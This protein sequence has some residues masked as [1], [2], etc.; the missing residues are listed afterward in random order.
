[1]NAIAAPIRA[2]VDHTF[3][4]RT[5]GGKEFLKPSDMTTQHLY[6]TLRMIW[7]HKMP[8][9]ARMYPYIEHEFSAYYTDK[10]MKL[11][12]RQLALELA[13]R[14]LTKGMKE[15]LEHMIRWLARDQIA[16]QEQKLFGGEK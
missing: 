12:I 2:E 11:A 15:G 1:M 6:S 10:Y 3:K 5:A 13:T 8:E 7:N 14:R 9:A 4:W 16:M